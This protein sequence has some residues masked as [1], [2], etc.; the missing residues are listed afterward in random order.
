MPT[1]RRSAF[2]LV[3]LGILSIVTLARPSPAKACSCDV[4]GPGR[5][6]LGEGGK[7][8]R[9]ATGIAYHGLNPLLDPKYAPRVVKERVELLRRV[10]DREIAVPFTVIHR[11]RIDLIIP[12]G[13]LQAGD[14]YTITVREYGGDSPFRRWGRSRREQA[15]QWK[16]PPALPYSTTATVTVTSD[17]LSLAD[18]TLTQS[19]RHRQL[20]EHKDMHPPGCWG[21]WSPIPSTSPSGSRPRSSPTATISCSRRSSTAW[22]DATR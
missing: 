11:G 10:G 14:V 6:Y 4:T 9:D 12:R 7:L 8:P 20:V 13:G 1:L 3:I 15:R 17:E 5:F 19:P 2:V 21:R 22:P 18:V 16:N